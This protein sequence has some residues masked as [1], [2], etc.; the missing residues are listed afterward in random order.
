[1]KVMNRIYKK[2]PLETIA[3]EIK[4]YVGHSSV[5]ISMLKMLAKRHATLIITERENFDAELVKYSIR[6]CYT[7]RRFRLA[8]FPGPLAIFFC[9]GLQ[10]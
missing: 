7:R 9:N 3:A 6:H 8:D 5:S 1:M 10:R 2:I 4:S